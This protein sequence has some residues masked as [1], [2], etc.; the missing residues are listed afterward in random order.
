MTKQSYFGQSDSSSKAAGAVAPGASPTARAFGA[1]VHTGEAGSALFYVVARS[2]RPD[3]AVLAAGGRVV[4][5]LPR[6]T[7]ALAIAPLAAHSVLRAHRD[8]KLAGPVTVDAERLQRFTR[9]VGTAGP[10]APASR[11]SP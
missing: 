8:L 9:L 3:A 1:N 4:T 6:E 2:G 10:S 7:D 5:R 11:I